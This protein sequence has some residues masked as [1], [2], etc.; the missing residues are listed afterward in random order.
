MRSS[1]EQAKL[2][3]NSWKERS[4]PIFVV[5]VSAEANV[6]FLALVKDDANFPFVRFSVLI[7]DSGVVVTGLKLEATFDFTGVEGFEYS[8]PREAPP[9]VLEPERKWVCLL[10]LN[11]PSG[12]AATFGELLGKE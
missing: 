2:L 7:D 6:G 5:L 10:Q 4:S 8:D 1:L 11:F 3:F 12:D 9:E